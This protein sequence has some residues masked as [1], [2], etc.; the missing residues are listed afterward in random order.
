MKC[1]FSIVLIA[2]L[3]SMYAALPSSANAGVV[4][5]ASVSNQGTENVLF[6][7]PGLIGTGTTVQGITNNTQVIVNFIG[8]EELT[9]PS[10]GQARIESSDGNGFRDLT[11]ELDPVGASFTKIVLNL[12][13]VNADGDGQVLF[14]AIEVGGGAATFSPM[15][16]WPIGAAG[17]NFFT[18]VS[19]IGF[20]SVSFTTNIGVAVDLDN[21]QQIRLG[22]VND[23]VPGVPEVS[24]LAAWG[25]CLAG[26]GLVMYRRNRRRDMT[27]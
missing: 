7:E 21:V 15:A 17:E 6:N 26:A 14:S 8:T 22:G 10:G 5:S 27:A 4:I 11:I 23:G 24:S 19:D 1:R 25:V 13:V 12:D 16:L 9:T 2:A 20:E 18:L 3:L